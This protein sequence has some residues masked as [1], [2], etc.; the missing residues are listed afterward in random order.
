M[1]APHP[2]RPLSPEDYAGASVP[3]LEQLRE[4]RE[5][6]RADLAALADKWADAMRA[7][8][9]PDYEIPTG[10]IIGGRCMHCGGVFVA[11][12]EWCE[13]GKK[14]KRYV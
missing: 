3:T 7:L 12:A 2:L 8:A 9:T 10:E 14:E 1:S 5:R 13:H 4:A 11:H 6:G